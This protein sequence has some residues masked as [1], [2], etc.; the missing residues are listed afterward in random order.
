MSSDSTLGTFITMMDQ[1][2]H[3]MIATF[4]DETKLRVYGNSFDMMKKSN[5]RKIL[6]LFME[7]T[8]PYAQQ[9]MNKDES[10]LLDDTIPLVTELNLK[11]IW[12]SPMITDTTKDAIWAHLNTLLMFGTTISNIPAGLMQGIEK[13]AVDYAAQ[14]GDSP[15]MD[16]QML[17]AGLQ[18]M[19]QNMK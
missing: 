10:I 2:I 9:I 7:S 12:T 13:L 17:M 18:S 14:M 5:P 15:S 11:H 19:M 4:P 1:F 8:G 16:P 6:N 3:E